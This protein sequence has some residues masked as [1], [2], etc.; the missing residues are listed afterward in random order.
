MTCVFFMSVCLANTIRSPIH[1]ARSTE[2]NK[3]NTP[4]QQVYIAPLTTVGNLPF[5]RV[6]KV[7]NPPPPP[8]SCA[9]AHMQ[10]TTI[11]P[12]Q[13]LHPNFFFDPSC[14]PRRSFVM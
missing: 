6:M 5:R 12:P 1:G 9:G 2:S 3:S 10:H 13:P 4:T 14:V 11:Q 8:I 7:K